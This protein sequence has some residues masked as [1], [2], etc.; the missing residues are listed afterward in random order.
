MEGIR[1]VPTAHRKCWHDLAAVGLRLRRIEYR[2]GTTRMES[3]G[4]VVNGAG[5]MWG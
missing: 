1:V 5:T 2:T 4:D 3:H